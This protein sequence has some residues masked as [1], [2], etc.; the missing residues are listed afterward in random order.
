MQRS[1]DGKDFTD[2]LTATLAV[3]SRDTSTAVV[4]IWWN[5][6]EEFDL[7]DVRAAF[8]AYLF[9]YDPKRYPLVPSTI[10]D[11]V[12]DIRRKRIGAEQSSMLLLPSPA[13]QRRVEHSAASIL[14]PRTAPAIEIPLG[15]RVKISGRTQWRGQ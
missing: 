6:L 15:A 8:S 7:A 14:R 3:F 1:T 5:V 9:G 11:I 13:G 4:G 2:L 12:R 10:T